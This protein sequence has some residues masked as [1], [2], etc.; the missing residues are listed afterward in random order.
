MNSKVLLVL[1]SLLFISSYS[2]ARDKVDCLSTPNFD[3]NKILD[4]ISTGLGKTSLK[5]GFYLT[6]YN[7]KIDADCA[8]R[9]KIPDLEKFYRNTMAEGT[10]CMDRLTSSGIGKLGSVNNQCLVKLFENKSNPPKLLCGGW[11]FGNDIWAVGSFPGSSKRHP[12]LWLGPNITK[13]IKDDPM[14]LK[15]TIFHEMLHNCG[16]THSEGMEIP[17]T[18]EQC[19]FSNDLS[20]DRKKSAC[21]ICGGK[22]SNEEDPAYIKDLFHWSKLHLSWGND[23]RQRVYLTSMRSG[24]KQTF[25]LVINELNITNEQKDF[26]VKVFEAKDPAV[27][28]TML[29]DFSKKYQE[30]IPANLPLKSLLEW[31]NRT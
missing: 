27:K 21:N 30:A 5:D 14:E 6:G 28:K 16:Y 2:F 17:Y 24:D 3:F 13:L 12:Y 20:A 22:Y 7:L 11:P 26:L 15:A 9:I 10:A 31:M 1:T 19:C 29:T 25:V 4:Q 8:N 18:C 23:M